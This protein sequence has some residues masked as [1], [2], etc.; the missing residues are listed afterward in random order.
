M[1][2]TLPVPATLLAAL[3]LAPIGQAGDLL[4]ERLAEKLAKPFVKNAD[5]ARSYDEALKRAREEGK[6]VFAYFA[7]SYEP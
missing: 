3:L 7:R 6:L 4:Q 2:R 1:P 5:W